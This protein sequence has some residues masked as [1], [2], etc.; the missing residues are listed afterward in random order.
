MRKLSI[1]CLIASFLLLFGCI[2]P[3]K[4]FHTKPVTHEV[5]LTVQGVDNVK[6]STEESQIVKSMEIPN[7]DLTLSYY[8]R[9]SGDTAYLKITSVGSYT[10]DAIWSDFQILK[11]KGIKKLTIYMNNPGGSSFD[12]AGIYDQL[13]LLKENGVYIVIEGYGFIA[14]AA[15][16][17]LSVGDRRIASENMTFL[18]HPGALFKWGMFTET[19][20]DLQS[21]TRMMEMCRQRYATILSRHCKLSKDEIL[22]MM[23][24]D[25]WFDSKQ[26]KEWGIVDEIR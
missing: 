21:Q 1:F 23:D 20:K 19:L 25:T 16:P 4:G 7:E 3:P 5:K 24:E 22:K 14:S 13:R 26:A 15:V 9:I 18:V 6:V 2:T 10:T 12:G 17:I 8:C 11:L